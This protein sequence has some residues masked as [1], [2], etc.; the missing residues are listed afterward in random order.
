MSHDDDNSF[1]GPSTI[2]VS[3]GASPILPPRQSGTAE[4]GYD[5]HARREV[6]GSCRIRALHPDHRSAHCGSEIADTT[7]RE[8]LALIRENRVIHEEQCVNLN[9][10]TNAM[11]PK[12][13]ALLAQ[14]PRV[15]SFA[16][17]SRRQV[18]DGPGGGRA[19]RDHRGPARRRDLRA[20]LRRDPRP[21][22]ARSPTSTCS[23]RRPSPGDTI[24]APP[25]AIG[26]HV[27]HH[28]AGC[29]RALRASSRIR[30]RS[31]PPRYTVDVDGLRSRARRLEPEADHHRRQPQPLPASGPRAPADRRRGRGAT[32]CSTPPTCAA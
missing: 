30:R 25:A 32:C 23:W 6:V 17:L 7:E 4:R 24:I 29:R 11:N 16:G 10:A 15:T 13:E 27:T 28:A 2:D 19:D 18:R 5:V 9:P 31:T 21:L 8:I 22:R 26:G 20:P 12:A 14:G 1:A 3:E